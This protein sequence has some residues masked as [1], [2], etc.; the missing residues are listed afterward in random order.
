ME[1]FVHER[2]PC[3]AVAVNVRTP[4]REAEIQ[5]AMAECSDSTLI[6]RPLQLPFAVP[7]GQFLIDR[8]LRA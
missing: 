2:R 6:I 1:E 8:A 4:V 3:E 7:L 5:A